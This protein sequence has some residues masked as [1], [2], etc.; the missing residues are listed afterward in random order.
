MSDL[1]KQQEL[2]QFIVGKTK[3]GGA[4]TT[5]CSYMEHCKKEISIESKSDEESWNCE[6]KMRNT[7]VAGEAQ[8]SPR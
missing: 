4:K 6:M 2:H 3:K 5:L 1:H 7:K 8:T